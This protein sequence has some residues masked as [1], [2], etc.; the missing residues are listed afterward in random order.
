M[1]SD[2]KHILYRA[3]HE[4]RAMGDAS[5]KPLEGRIVQ[6]YHLNKIVGLYVCDQPSKTCQYIER[7]CLEYFCKRY[8]K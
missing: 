8:K 3:A 7:D 2:K 4:A 1:R 5:C 6:C